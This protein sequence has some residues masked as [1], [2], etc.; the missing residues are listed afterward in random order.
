MTLAFLTEAALFKTV[1]KAFSYF[2]SSLWYPAYRTPLLCIICYN[3]INWLSSNGKARRVSWYGNAASRTVVW[4]ITLSTISKES[5]QSKWNWRMWMCFWISS[6]CLHGRW[7]TLSQRK[8]D[9]A[10]ICIEIGYWCRML[11]YSGGGD[12]MVDASLSSCH[13]IRVKIRKSTAAWPGYAR[14]SL[15]QPRSQSFRCRQR[16][17]EP[18]KRFAKD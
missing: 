14:I 4:H 3:Q 9:R 12:P 7:A 17:G 1:C 18:R 5:V 6:C 10:S 2:Y 11:S 16:I 15:T 8:K 13:F